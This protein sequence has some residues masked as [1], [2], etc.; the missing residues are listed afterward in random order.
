M[1]DEKCNLFL[2]MLK[3][4]HITEGGSG[5]KSDN[6][7]YDDYIDLLDIYIKTTAFHLQELIIK[8]NKIMNFG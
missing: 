8:M 6:D 1:T 4:D 7:Y 2:K 5:S 3:T